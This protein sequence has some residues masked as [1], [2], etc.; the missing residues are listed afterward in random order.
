VQYE[1]EKK[2][3][4]R[5]KQEEHSDKMSLGVNMPQM[6]QAKMRKVKLGL[7]DLFKTEISSI[8]REFKLRINDWE[9]WQVFEGAYEEA[10]HLL[11]LHVVKT[12]KSDEKKIHDFRKVNPR[13]QKTR[14]E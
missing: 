13:M 2:R 10:L 6:S 1:S 8:M 5:R 12:L 3:E 9:H 4:F 14:A 7:A 11:R